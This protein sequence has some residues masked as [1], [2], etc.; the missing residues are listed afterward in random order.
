VSA[1][2][3]AIEATIARA[4]APPARIPPIRLMGDIACPW[5]YLALH[6]LRQAF[7][8][9]VELDWHPFLLN[10]GDLA[11]QRRRLAGPVAHY[12]AGLT[13]P[14]TP[15]SLASSVDTRLAHAVILVAAGERRAADAAAALF[16][17]R[18]AAG[19]SLVTAE[20]F[21]A[22][23]VSDVGADA[24]ARWC[25]RAQAQLPLVERAA[26]AARLAG[27]SEIPLAVVDNAFV[28]GGLQP[29]EA[30]RALVELADIRD[31]HAGP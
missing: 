27:V 11:R 20:E 4:A 15:A 16:A 1:D 19:E 18:F 5:T 28:I 25:G 12:A 21:R 2:G 17:A 6:A 31:H 10:L 3:A 7:G 14:F 8:E 30:Y 29:P 13:V 26:R 9:D 24:A 23:L 22:A